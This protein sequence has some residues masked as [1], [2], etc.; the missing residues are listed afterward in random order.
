MNILEILA[1]TATLIPLFNGI[2]FLLLFKKLREV[3]KK[4]S[5]IEMLILAITI[6]QLW[7][8]TMRVLAMFLKVE[9]DKFF[10][11]ILFFPAYLL[12]TALGIYLYQQFHKK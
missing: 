5:F 10:V 12:I 9:T 8:G 7:V 6:N 1:W 3:D 11:L 4:V 2:L